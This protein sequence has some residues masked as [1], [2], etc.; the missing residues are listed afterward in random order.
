VHDRVIRLAE[1]NAVVQTLLMTELAERLGPYRLLRVLGEGGMG[2]VY[3]A[4]QLEPVRRRVALKALKIGMDTRAFIAR[5]EVERQALAVMEHP[6]I[7]TVLDAGETEGRPYYVME[8]V[9]GVALNTFCDEHRLSTHE[10]IEL[11]LG[12]CN[13][14]H[15]AH[16][17]A[18][19]H[20]DLKPSNILV[21]I[22][23]DRPQPK[24]IDFGIAKAIGQ[25]LTDK[26]LVTGF[27]ETVGT[28]AYMSPEQWSADLPDVD[29]R[30]DIYSLGVI[31]YELLAGRLPYDAERLMRA[32]AAAPVLLRDVTPPPPSTAVRS[33]G[34][35]S[36][37]LAQARRTDP[38]SWARDLRG[39]IDWITLKAM[40]PDR[41]RRYETAH[42]LA[43]DIERHL[44][45]EPIVARPPSLGYR[46]S[47]FLS[48]HRIGV[49]IAAGTFAA[50][51]ALT[52]QSVVQAQR[53]T[54]ERD[55]ARAEASKARALNS[56]LQSTLLS[57]D[58]INGI[59][60]DATVL[61]ALDSATARLSREGFESPAVE[62]SVKSA[63]GWAYFRVALYDRAEPLLTTA[64][65][66]RET[67][68]PLDSDG[69]GES[70]VRVAQLHDKRARYDSAAAMFARGIAVRRAVGGD[71][72]HDLAEAL[73][74]SGGFLRDRGDSTRALAAFTEAGDIFRVIGDSAGSAS[75]D[76]EAGVLE[77]GRGNLAEAE[78]LMRR[79][80]EFKRRKFGR[81]A[82]VAGELNNLG[83]VL[84]DLKRPAQAESAY[85][86][87][88]DI[89]LATLGEEHDVVTATMN[90]IGLL[91][92]NLGRA[93]EAQV[94]LR[95]AL[96][97]D[98]RKLGTNN[99]GV[100][101]DLLNL[102]QTICRG[103]A[104]EEG[105]AFA[106]RAARIFAKADPRSWMQGQARLV[107]GQC[108]TRLSRFDEA[109]RDLKVA[110][111]YLE[112]GLGSTHRRVDSARVRLAELEEAR[113]VAK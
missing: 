98:E 45:R 101:I 13:A 89:G 40:A 84:E 55:R 61:Q 48:R 21:V 56:F 32:G 3:E 81:H 46:A 75:V 67:L 70:L 83:S 49:G 1:A 8:L 79:S 57:P 107:R 102:A 24:V 59:G 50:G 26:T 90:N 100:G 96:S 54:R 19:I 109:E 42:E 63:I 14:V 99:P 62:A 82:L 29:T 36:G 7:A 66:I 10:R 85:R 11:F 43:L 53:V 94:F 65:R 4:E 112:Q 86:E 72:S 113:R 71:H 18:V 74:V 76:D 34:H 97:I 44:R 35:D 39:D 33:L 78:R 41:R 58:P 9:A 2:I 23:D 31:L 16:Q 12:I 51:L 27:G 88:L 38:K 77:L 87:A 5:F 110:L 108:L 92:S 60:R 37:P 69:L 28:P 95:R 47:R 73:V 68:T 6:N 106:D 64:L 20:R 80:L 105:A 91:I 103:R 22:Q 111:Q 25:R 17:K 15:H 104:T 93:D 30:A 52:V